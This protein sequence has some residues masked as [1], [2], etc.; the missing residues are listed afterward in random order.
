M[1]QPTDMRSCLLFTGA[2][3]ATWEL[4]ISK[5]KELVSDFQR[6]GKALL[7]LSINGLETE[8]ADSPTFLGTT[9][10]SSQTGWQLD[11]QHQSSSPTRT[12][13]FL[14]HPQKVWSVQRQGGCST[15]LPCFHLCCIRTATPQKPS[16]GSIWTE[17]WPQ[18]QKSPHPPLSDIYKTY[19]QDRTPRH[20]ASA[21][22]ILQTLHSRKRARASKLRVSCLLN[23]RTYW[24]QN[25]PITKWLPIMHQHL[26]KAICSDILLLLCTRLRS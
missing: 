6:D 1:N 20:P 14:R 13:F 23:N 5:A 9:T 19:V 18:P 22:P 15:D 25:C 24:L 2:A 21:N 10:I 17:L 7:P 3:S 12:L 16:R 8:W 26:T 11:L 4:N